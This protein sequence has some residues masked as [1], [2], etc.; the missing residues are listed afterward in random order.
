MILTNKGRL[1]PNIWSETHGQ[2]KNTESIMRIIWGIE[3]NYRQKASEMPDSPL[4]PTS[5]EAR[6]IRLFLC[7][8][9]YKRGW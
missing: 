3:A 4:S 7:C 6:H 2:A 9:W 8:D 1:G 5:K